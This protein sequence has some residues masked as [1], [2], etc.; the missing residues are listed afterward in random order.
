MNQETLDALL[1]TLQDLSEQIRAL[2]KKVYFQDA[3]FQALRTYV[4][5]RISELAKAE[6]KNEVREL[7]RLLRA[8]YDQY[9]SKI[10][11]VAPAF[12]AEID[13]RAEMDPKDQQVWYLALDDLLTKDDP[14]GDGSQGPK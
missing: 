11:N 7:N 2:Q 6:R 12:A 1:K 13:I 4:L 3:C 5:A 10:E 8:T 14:P 9:I